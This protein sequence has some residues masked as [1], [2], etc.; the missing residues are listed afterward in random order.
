MLPVGL[1]IV[2]NFFNYLISIIMA[3]LHVEKKSRKPI[4]PWILIILLVVGLLVWWFLDQSNPELIIEQQEIN[5]V[6]P[7][8]IKYPEASLE[9][10]TRA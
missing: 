9:Q 1:S 5:M 2:F 3:E 4:W 10:F 6:W 8:A 7:D